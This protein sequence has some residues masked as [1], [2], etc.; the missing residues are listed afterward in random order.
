MV[1]EDTVPVEEDARTSDVE[2]ATIWLEEPGV[3]DVAVDVAADALE[4]TW[5]VAWEEEDVDP[6]VA[7]ED[8][9]PIPLPLLAR[10]LLS[11]EDACCGSTHWPW[12]LQMSPAPQSPAS[13]QPVFSSPA[14]CVHAGPNTPTHPTTIHCCHAFM[15]FSLLQWPGTRGQGWT[16]G[17]LSGTV[18]HAPHV[19]GRHAAGSTEVAV[20]I[21]HR[22]HASEPHVPAVPLHH[23]VDRVP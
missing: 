15:R 7:R 16:V 13:L 6:E 4:E 2:E 21:P 1:L 3:A 18:K 19:P 12:S 8:V 10:L 9:V 17:C 23:M 11:P 5:D 20:P 14:G 22:T